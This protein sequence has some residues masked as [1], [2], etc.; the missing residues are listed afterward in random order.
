MAYRL[1]VI[2]ELSTRECVDKLISFLKRDTRP[3]FEEDVAQGDIPLFEAIELLEFP[4]SIDMV[5]DLLVLEWFETNDFGIADFS[6]L[7]KIPAIEFLAAYEISDDPMSEDEGNEDWF[8]ILVDAKFVRV[9]NQSATK[10]L[11]EDIINLF[12]ER[13]SN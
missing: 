10:Y 9:S 1:S 8:W 7:S 3:M 6:K 4:S 13:F 2:L 12:K 5:N 11:K